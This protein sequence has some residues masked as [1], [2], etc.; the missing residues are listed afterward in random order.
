MVV[1][2][3]NMVGFGWVGTLSDFA[4]LLQHNTTKSLP[5]PDIKNNI[6]N[7]N[8]QYVL[9]TPPVRPVGNFNYWLPRTDKKLNN[10]N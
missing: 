7:Q 9:I 5:T 2:Y 8:T 6:K 3:K 10:V 4:K 1:V